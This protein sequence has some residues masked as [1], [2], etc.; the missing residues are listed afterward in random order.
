MDCGTNSVV[1]GGISSR[2][3]GC[4]PDC[5]RR[6]HIGERL[7]HTCVRWHKSGTGVNLEW[8][9]MGWGRVQGVRV[10]GLWHFLW[11]CERSV[12]SRSCS[13]SSLLRIRNAGHVEGGI[14]VDI[15]WE[16]SVSVARNGGGALLVQMV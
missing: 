15:A 16:G 1:D 6:R 3:V 10:D 13:P 4:M 12:I 7:S 14:R 11:R 8:M 9:R 5:P 2:A